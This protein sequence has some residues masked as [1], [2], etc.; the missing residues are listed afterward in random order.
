MDDGEI[1]T[2]PRYF[3]TRP[4]HNASIGASDLRLADVH[5]YQLSK[6]LEASWFRPTVTVP[7]TLAPYPSPPF[8]RDDGIGR[9]DRIGRSDKVSCRLQLEMF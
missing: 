4:T 9:D 1:K 5:I 7:V 6:P 2:D 3:V 8:R